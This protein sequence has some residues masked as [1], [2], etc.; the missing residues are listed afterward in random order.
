MS[1]NRKFNPNV[2]ETPRPAHPVPPFVNN[3]QNFYQNQG[4]YQQFP[5]FN[6]N[7]QQQNQSHN[8]NIRPLLSF[9]QGDLVPPPQFRKFNNNN[10]INNN[11]NYRRPGPACSR[12]NYQG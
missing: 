7:Y 10:N 2:W 12:N 11:P 1:F 4:N 9:P 8:Q 3:Q 5:N 6:S